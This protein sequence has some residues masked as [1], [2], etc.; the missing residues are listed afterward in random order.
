MIKSNNSFQLWGWNLFFSL[1]SGDKTEPIFF[2]ICLG[3]LIICLDFHSRSFHYARVILSSLWEDW[4]FII[5][6]TTIKGKYALRACNVNHR[7]RLED[8]D[9]VAEVKKFGK[10]LLPEVVGKK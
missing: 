10:K 6:D 7:S 8:F 9:L 2:R 4:P 3:I 1:N 5:S